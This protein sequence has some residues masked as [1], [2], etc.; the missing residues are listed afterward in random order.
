[1][2]DFALELEKLLSLHGSD[3]IRQLKL[4]ASLNDFRPLKNEKGI[5]TVGG[6]RCGDYQNLLNAARKAACHGYN[7][8]MLPNPKGVRSADFIFEQQGVYKMYDLKTINGNASVG[9]RLNES[10]GQS[11]RVVLNMRCK[12]DTRALAL[13]IK[14][15][16]E[17]SSEPIEVAI[18][19]GRKLILIDR[20]FAS[21]ER[22]LKRFRNL[23]EK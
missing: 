19:K 5:F 3:F 17:R 22:F 4:I 2:S 14:R 7:V 18:L 16:F 8:F 11:N 20:Q 1:M 21:S 10:I 23:Y 13:D 15:Y 12:Y 9:N 6:E